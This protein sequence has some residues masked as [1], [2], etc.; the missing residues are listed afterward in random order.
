MRA[1]LRLVFVTKKH[2]TTL[3]HIVRVQKVRNSGDR[4]RATHEFHE[5]NQDFSDCRMKVGLFDL[6]LW[7]LNSTVLR[8]TIF[9]TRPISDARAFSDIGEYVIRDCAADA[10]AVFI[11][12][13]SFIDDCAGH[14]EKAYA[15]PIDPNKP[16]DPNASYRIKLKGHARGWQELNF[17]AR[18]RPLR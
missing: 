7:D 9:L 4:Q 13:M 18:T 5:G 2:V 6:T 14:E 11:F 15:L 8:P 12:F 16:N 17:L 10:Y 1:L 3:A